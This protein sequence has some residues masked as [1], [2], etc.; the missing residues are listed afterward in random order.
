MHNEREKLGVVLFMECVLRDLFGVSMLENATLFNTLMKAF[1]EGIDF[2]EEDVETCA[3]ILVEGL[4]KKLGRKPNERE[5]EMVMHKMQL[6]IVCLTEGEDA[7]RKRAAELDE[8][9]FPEAP[10]HE[11]KSRFNWDGHI[12]A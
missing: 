7:A 9:F 3:L 10:K 2:T 6:A 1:Q 5:R 8:Q 11:P 4:T 12:D